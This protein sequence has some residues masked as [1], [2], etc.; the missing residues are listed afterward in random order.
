MRLNKTILTA[1]LLFV[2]HLTCISLL[3]PIASPY[4]YYTRLSH[5]F[6]TGHVC[7]QEGPPWLNELVSIPE[8]GFCV[9][10]PITPSILFLPFVALIPTISQTFLSHL[11][12]AATS[13]VVFLLLKKMKL[14][15]FQAFCMTFFWTV[16]TIFFS[17]SAVGSAWYVAQTVGSFFLLLSLLFFDPKKLPF[18][19]L[20]G[21]MLGVA[22]N[23]R[24]PLHLYVFYIIGMIVIFW[25]GNIKKSMI[26]LIIFGLGF[27]P[28]FLLQRGY[29][30][31]R[32]HS[33][34][35]NG[36]YLIAGKFEEKDFEHGEF[37]PINIP[38]HLEVFLFKLPKQIRNFPYIVP[39]Y[40]G[41][42]IFVTS[43]FLVIGFFYLLLKKR[44]IEVFTILAILALEM[45]HGTVGFTQF[46]Y[47]F[48]LDVYPL[49]FIGFVDFVK[50]YKLRILPFLLLLW[51][52]I[53]NTWGVLAFRL[54]WFI[55]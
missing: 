50:Q 51:S 41:M 8:K 52:V 53:V 16:G 7:L 22:A 17:L 2:I 49:L 39:S 4:D 45:S 9:V 21:F 27:L 18:L 14:K 5:A 19:L 42:S 44:Y 37:N 34:G 3:Y 12:F 6:L 32:F 23:A 35:D 11:V 40:Y 31:I 29:N 47:R 33:F 54:G 43:P 55:W 20:S 24:L 46:G 13:V 36:Y 1:L 10:Y 30:W 15:T 48:G 26:S 25:K 28:F 38:K